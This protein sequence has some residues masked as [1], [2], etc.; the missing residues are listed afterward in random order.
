MSDIQINPE[1]GL[2]FVRDPEGF[3]RTYQF[4][5][6]DVVGIVFRWAIRRGTV[7]RVTATRVVVSYTGDD[8]EK[9]GMSFTR[10]RCEEVGSG[11]ESY[12]SHTVRLISSEKAIE[13]AA[14]AKVERARRLQLNAI[15]AAHQAIG[16]R[17]DDLH[18]HTGTLAAS[19]RALADMVDAYHTANPGLV[20]KPE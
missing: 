1:S 6:G 13:M 5:V 19:L 11:K 9:V 15:H 10:S 4:A 2:S 14:A 12:A 16:G 8:K 7:E 18:V 20:R 17:H 3:K